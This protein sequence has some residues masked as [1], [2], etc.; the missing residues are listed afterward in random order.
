AKATGDV[1]LQRL[2]ASPA[3]DMPFPD[4]DLG[5]Q[6]RTAARLLEAGVDVATL[7][8][9]QD[10]YDTHEGQPGAHAYLLET[11]SEA[12]NAFA[13]A[14]QQIGLWDQVTVVTYSEFGRTA[15]ENAS[16]G[17]DHG[18]AAPL[19]I[20]GGGVAG[21]MTGRAPSLTALVD[22]EMVHTTDYRTVYAAL[23]RDLWGIDAP[24]FA[25]DDPALSILRG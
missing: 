21:G 18:T 20:T 22:N 14:M 15:R 10:G 6:L 7:K 3:R 23:L 8:V 9:V 4:T 2:A 11:L 5:Q 17:T 25:T 16:G 1:I 19:F 13:A 24:I 12:I